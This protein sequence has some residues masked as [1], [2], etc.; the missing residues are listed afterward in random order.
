[1]TELTQEHLQKIL[2][3]N[4]LTGAFKWLHSKGTA[5][6]G[7]LA[8]RLIK[9]YRVIKIDGKSYFAHRLAWLYAYGNFPE[10]HIDHINRNKDD[11][12]II[13]LRDVSRDVNQHNH[14]KRTDNT[15]GYRGVWF[16]KA[17][18]KYEARVRFNGKRILIG[19]F[20]NPEDASNAYENKKNEINSLLA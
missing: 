20:L 4:E 10:S 6:A 1:M 19:Y 3:Y 16:N 14:G 13:N 15:S 18:N 5:K 7:N 11:N 2:S 9:G 8:G 17:R 12:S